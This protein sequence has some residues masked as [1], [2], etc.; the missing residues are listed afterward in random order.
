[1][2]FPFNKVQISTAKNTELNNLRAMYM[3]MYM[4][5]RQS[6]QEYSSVHLLGHPISH[7]ITLH[8]NPQSV[9]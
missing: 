9:L 3:Y 7:V 4:Q 2:G 5:E 6:I 1:M 8:T